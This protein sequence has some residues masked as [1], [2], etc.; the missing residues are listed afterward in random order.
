MQ[1]KLLEVLSIICGEPVYKAV[2]VE[3]NGIQ[4]VRP[5]YKLPERMV[6]RRK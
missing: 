2:F 5:V 6:I 4:V 3:S 1:E